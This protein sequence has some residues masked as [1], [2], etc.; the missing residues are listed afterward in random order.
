MFIAPKGW[1]ETL[2]VRRE[3]RDRPE[4]VTTPGRLDPEVLTQLLRSTLRT[5]CRASR[6][7][8]SVAGRTLVELIS[9]G[10]EPL[11]HR[12]IDAEN[13]LREAAAS[14]GGRYGNAA[15]VLLGLA[16]GAHGRPLKDRRRLAADL[17]DVL[18]DTFRRHH[19]KAILW[20]I[21]FALATTSG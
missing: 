17:L 15:Q 11:P 3:G 7:A 6:L 18:P 12:A 16:P 8:G 20:D 2:T 4:A 10:G 9:P 19:E 1:C 21:A 14:Y 13:R 5:G